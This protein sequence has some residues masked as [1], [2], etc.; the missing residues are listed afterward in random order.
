MHFGLRTLLF[1]VLLL[2]MLVLSYPMLFK[3]LNDARDKALADTR[4]NKQKLA[5]LAAVLSHNQNMPAEIERLQVA[6][7]KLQDKLPSETEMDKVLQDVW[8]AAKDN[9]LTVVSI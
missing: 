4:K 7:R 3:P 8:R 1:V 2:G 6:I 5:D 9:N